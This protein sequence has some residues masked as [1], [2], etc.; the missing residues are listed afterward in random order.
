MVLFKENY[1]TYFLTVYGFAEKRRLS[2]GS[3]RN[4][5]MIKGPNRCFPSN[6]AENFTTI[7]ALPKTQM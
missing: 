4:G 6:F 7:A 3:N 2:K 1:D 5:R